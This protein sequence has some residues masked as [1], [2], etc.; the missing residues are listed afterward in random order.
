VKLTPSDI[1]GIRQR[2]ES[3]CTE[4]SGREM[5]FVLGSEVPDLPIRASCR[6]LFCWAFGQLLRGEIGE[7]YVDDCAC[8]LIS[9]VAIL[10]AF[11][12]FN[13]DNPEI[14]NTIERE[15][16]LVG[17]HE[18]AHAVTSRKPEIILST[19]ELSNCRE[20]VQM[21]SAEPRTTDSGR[22]PPW[23]GHGVQ[24][25]RAAIHMCHRSRQLGYE[26][27][28]AQGVIDCNCY[29]LS[30]LEIVYVPILRDECERLSG[31]P[32]SDVLA[33]PASGAF[34]DELVR[35]RAEYF[36]SLFK[37]EQE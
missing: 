29:A 6:G 4:L 2:C 12:G 22:L 34:L 16:Q 20:A 23:Q 26:M 18:T 8:A 33:L 7:R 1:D 24:F 36:R 15:F 10:S 9:D 32:L 30:R 5:R 27:L 35:D 3:L 21:Q 37:K 11:D 25:M 31:I 17:L 19:V 28:P 13:S 14:R